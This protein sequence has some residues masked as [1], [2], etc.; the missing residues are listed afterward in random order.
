VVIQ[1]GTGEGA[2]RDQ[3]IDYLGPFYQWGVVVASPT[4][5]R[6]KFANIDRAD[7]AEPRRGQVMKPRGMET[8]RRRQ[9]V[10]GSSTASK[11]KVSEEGLSV[12]ESGLGRNRTSTRAHKEKRKKFNV[13][14]L[15]DEDGLN[16]RE[17]PTTRTR[18]VIR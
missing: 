6:L 17:V 9:G 12:R 3:S 14:Y 7:R 1:D 4:V 5:A 10:D 16:T 8:E 11:L 2:P 13:T 15:L 18:N